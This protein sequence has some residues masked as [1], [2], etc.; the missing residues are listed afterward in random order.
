M[1]KALLFFIALAL[2]FTFTLSAGGQKD[3]G[4]TAVSQEKVKIIFTS[5]RTED[6][7][8]MNR[9]NAVYMKKYP[10]VEI[11]FQPINDNEYDA[12]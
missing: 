4:G 9:I 6:I 10:N 1:K 8:R 7:E 5:W 3:Q 11:V 2:V 12:Q